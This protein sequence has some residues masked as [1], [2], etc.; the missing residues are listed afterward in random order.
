MGGIPELN[1]AKIMR[2]IILTLESLHANR[3]IMR[4]VKTKSIFIMKGTLAIKFVDFTSC[5]EIPWGKKKY[6]DDTIVG[7]PAYLAPEVWTF[8]NTT[9]NDVWSAGCISYE[10]HYGYSPFDR[11]VAKRV[12]GLIC[13]LP[14]PDAQREAYLKDKCRRI[15]AEI[16]KTEVQFPALRDATASDNFVSFT[17]TLLAVDPVQRPAATQCL[18]HPFLIAPKR[19]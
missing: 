2:Q 4:D 7:S 15:G 12:D 8:Q 19:K 10:L 3:L 16:G 1:I 17:R 5:V 14:K 18:E 6:Q 11:W 9:A 13:G